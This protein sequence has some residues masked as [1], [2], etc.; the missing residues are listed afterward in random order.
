M[1]AA[2]TYVIAAC[3]AQET[4]RATLSSLLAQTRPDWAAVIV[5]DGSTDATARVA[6][7][8]HDGR[9]RIVSQS[10]T[11]LAGARNRGLH[12]ADPS[13]PAMCFL[14]AD[15]G[16]H[17]DHA[18]AMVRALAERDLSA[19]SYRFVGPRLE[20]LDWEI[21]VS[22]HDCRF[23][24]LIEFN[25]LAVGAVGVRR[26]ALDCVSGPDGPFDRSLRVHEDW[27][28]WLRLTRAGAI[29][30]EP[31]G[32]ILFDYRLRAD[33]LTSDLEM[34]WRVGLR[35]IRSA[36][37]EPGLTEAALRRW[38]LRHLARSIAR[39]DAD[40]VRSALAQLG[41]IG[42]EDLDTLAG[43]LRWAL[44]R[45]DL[46]S[47]TIAHEHARAWRGRVA[48]TLEGVP[49]LGAL[50]TRLHFAPERW[51]RVVAGAARRLGSGETLVIYGLGRNG[52]RALAAARRAGLAPIVID[53]HAQP[54]PD[55]ASISPE[56]IDDS[57]VVL[58]TPD[59]RGPILERL[60][61]LG[62]RRVVLPEDL[63]AA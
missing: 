19:C 18:G 48:M 17:P 61:R 46:V 37:T 4:I 56:R 50:L 43:A 38:S 27:D 10:N 53:D 24:R 26:P 25:P 39:G 1:P 40:L 54:A 51:E 49:M 58:V 52:R 15:D 42:G 57:H 30:G 2:L 7:S 22:P 8:L 23:E 9:I 32:R 59:Q 44:C 11:G 35:V 3:N 20:D 13:C 6:A 5:D 36:G 31:D 62:V 47:P 14:D 16:V 60:G 33:S 29:W 34:M 55:L 12:E 63:D 21:P 41:Q 28:L 45:E